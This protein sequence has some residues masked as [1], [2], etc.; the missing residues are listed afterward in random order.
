MIAISPTLRSNSLLQQILQEEA[1]QE[2]PS[3]KWLE[4]PGDLPRMWGG[5]R[6][7]PFQILTFVP[8]V[9]SV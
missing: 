7:V 8:A 3:S 6:G 4:H 2:A 5:G 1:A 9:P